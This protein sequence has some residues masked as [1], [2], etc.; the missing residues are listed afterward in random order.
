MAKNAAKSGAVEI[1][2]LRDTDAAS[3]YKVRLEAL[4]R[5]PHAFSE[6]ADEHRV[7]SVADIAARMTPTPD[8]FS[9]GAFTSGKLVGTL[10]FERYRL[11]PRGP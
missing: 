10:R 6:A 4:E 3:L 8:G 7:H 5:E 9:L 2:V 11:A 1:R